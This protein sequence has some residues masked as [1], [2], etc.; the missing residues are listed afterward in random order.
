VTKDQNIA[1]RSYYYEKKLY[2]LLSPSS[3]SSWTTPTWPRFWI[4]VTSLINNVIEFFE[5]WIFGK[6]SLKLCFIGKKEFLGLWKVL[7]PVKVFTSFRMISL[8]VHAKICKWR[9]GAGH[10]RVLRI[11]A[12]QTLE[13]LWR[14][15]NIKEFILSKE[16]RIFLNCICFRTKI[17]QLLRGKHKL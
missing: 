5:M 8:N 11:I 9:L 1:R 10:F 12:H 16:P 4:S 13:N 7:L 6:I 15:K 14:K 3:S 2:L 17:I